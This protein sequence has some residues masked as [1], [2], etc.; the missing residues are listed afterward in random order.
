VAAFTPE[1]TLL[2]IGI[3]PSPGVDVLNVTVCPAASVTL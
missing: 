1:K 2:P 3:A